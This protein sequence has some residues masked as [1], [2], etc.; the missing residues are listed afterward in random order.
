M[1][2]DIS[3]KS[4]DL[5]QSHASKQSQEIIRKQKSDSE[6]HESNFA[7]A[8]P[9]SSETRLTSSS[10]YSG[11]V[12][13]NKADKR[14]DPTDADKPK[15]D[16]VSTQK[17][18]KEAK[19]D[20]ASTDSTNN[21]EKKSEVKPNK[22]GIYDFSNDKN[23]IN[24]FPNVI[25]PA[26]V[27]E[28]Q[29]KTTSVRPLPSI[30]KIF[31]TP[32]GKKFSVE[33]GQASGDTRSIN[34]IINTYNG[35]LG[36]VDTFIFFPRV[37][38]ESVYTADGQF[39]PYRSSR[40]LKNSDGSAD[41]DFNKAPDNKISYRLEVNG[42]LIGS[43]LADKTNITVYMRKNQ[44]FIHVVMEGDNTHEAIFGY[45]GF[46][47]ED[48][49]GIFGYVAFL[50]E[51]G[52]QFHFVDD[53][54][55]RKAANIKGNDDLPQRSSGE[56]DRFS[57]KPF[58]K[59][60]LSDLSDAKNI[61]KVRFGNNQVVRNMYTPL[62]SYEGDPKKDSIKRPTMEELKNTQ[63]TG[64][65]Y[66]SNDID[67]P[68]DGTFTTKNADKKP[69]NFNYGI[70]RDKDDNQLNTKHYYVTFRP[71]PTQLVVRYKDLQ[72]KIESGKKFGLYVGDKQ[73]AGDFKSSESSA[74][75]ELNALQSMITNKN[76]ALLSEAAG[77]LSNGFAYL[78]P[79]N[80][81]VKSAAEAPTNYEWV[82]EPEN[83][84]DINSATIDAKF[85]IAIHKDN[86]ISTQK[87]VTFV[88]RR[89]IATVKFINDDDK[90]PYATVK[91]QQGLSI[92][93]DGLTDQSMPANPTKAGFTFNGWYKDKNGTG[94]AFTASTIVSEDTTVYA[95]YT[96]IPPAPTPEPTPEPTPTPTPMPE[97]DVTPEPEPKPVPDVPDDSWIPVPEIVPENPEYSVVE[98][99]VLNPVHSSDKP[100]EHS[101]EQSFKAVDA[102][103]DY[104]VK[105]PAKHLPDTGVSLVM[106]I[107]ALFVSLFAGFGLSMF[108]SR[109]KH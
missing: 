14:N 49:S 20:R 100:V 32:Y 71:I 8:D 22:D 55:Y 63:I 105:A 84:A 107:S 94:D 67:T 9:S 42:K 1:Q 37:D 75:P 13:D 58:T 83:S 23:V 46:N 12:A 68:K 106:S 108:K 72:N 5:A 33:N 48:S 97:P 7:N 2:N 101:V 102:G 10:D 61:S 31:Y 78:S 91:V 69:G 36:R 89:K 6:D 41:F 56:A 64:Y 28:L 30:Q 96:Q 70:V 73:I 47:H 104:N 29:D 17:S 81:I 57:T 86:S 15:N 38:K 44:T 66:Y 39:Y 82:V 93:G 76:T 59:L 99:P 34:E 54:Q 85:N 18:V 3:A 45:E 60:D 62:L 95:I 24:P 25:T 88:L 103:E 50:P 79:G 43:N 53:L 98:Q 26:E 11:S 21:G 109:R 4:R 77:Y 40:E 80:Y 35:R 87:V 74:A 92:S 90:K 65:L 19:D 16:E 27:K 52:A 51:C